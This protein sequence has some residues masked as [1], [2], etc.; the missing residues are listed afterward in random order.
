MQDD[1]RGEGNQNLYQIIRYFDNTAGVWSSED[2]ADLT[3]HPLAATRERLLEQ[4]DL[5]VDA[6][7]S[8]HIFFKEFLGADGA[9]SSIKHLTGSLGAWTTRTIDATQLNLNWVKM[10]EVGG[11]RYLIGTS[12]ASLYL[13]DETGTTFREIALPPGMSGIYPYAA[14][15]QDGTADS[16]A[17][18][19]LILLNGDSGNYPDA[20]NYYVRIAKADI[21]L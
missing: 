19:D 3:S 1:F 13:L 7:G 21:G 2:L 8:V 17:Y 11:T 10:I 16:E 6:T 15:R 14:T 4:S 18:I 20:A 9:T 5:Y 12:H